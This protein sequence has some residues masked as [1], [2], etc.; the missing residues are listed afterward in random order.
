MIARERNIIKKRNTK[1]GIGFNGKG[2]EILISFF[3][4]MSTSF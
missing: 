3:Y 1:R 2:G 4:I